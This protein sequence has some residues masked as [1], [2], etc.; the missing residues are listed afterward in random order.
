MLQLLFF[1]GFG[2]LPLWVAL[3]VLMAGSYSTPSAD[4]WNV[5]PWLLLAAVPA[6]AITMA[7]AVASR[8]AFE[9]TAGSRSYK[10]RVATLWFTSAIVLVC[11]VAS[12]VW[13]KHQLEK[14]D[15]AHSRELALRLVEQN[16]AVIRVAGGRP[17][18]SVSEVTSTHGTITRY[19]LSVDGERRIYA[20]VKVAQ[21][22]GAPSLSLACITAKSPGQREAFKD[23]CQ[24]DAIQLDG[25]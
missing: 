16:D 6:C 3:A 8:V 15:H 9:R 20:V 1:G 17:T 7:I 2:L 19:D 22:D 13:W 23:V 10:L 25:Q 5:A 14:Q 18:V 24:T 11:L 21:V 4:Y 12:G